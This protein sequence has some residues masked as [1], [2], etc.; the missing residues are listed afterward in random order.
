MECQGTNCTVND[1]Y[2][3]DVAHSTQCQFEHFCAVRQLPMDRTVD[4]RRFCSMET[5][6][7]WAAF[8]WKMDPQPGWPA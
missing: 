2:N 1:S 7:A 5:E 6:H 4:N 3:A 8:T